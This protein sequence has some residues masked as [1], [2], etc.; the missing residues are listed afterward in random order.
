MKFTNEDKKRISFYEELKEF[1]FNENKNITDYLKS[2]NIEV[3]LSDLTQS[4][5]NRSFQLC[6]KTNQFNLTT[7]RY[8][9]GDIEKYMNDNDSKIYGF[10]VQDKYGDSGITGLC[11]ILP[12]EK[13]EMVVIDTFLMS[14]RVI[15]RNIEYAFMDFIINEMKTLNKTLI[16]ARYI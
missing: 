3:T 14:C 15:G 12:T 1:K 4:N 16:N 10:S 6:Q 8:T 11:I 7:K 2:L 5:L 13:K 9:E